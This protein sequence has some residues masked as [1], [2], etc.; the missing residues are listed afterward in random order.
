MTDENE[1]ET[2]EKQVTLMIDDTEIMTTSFDETVS[3]GVLQMSIGSAATNVADIQAYITQANGI[4][5][6]LNNGKMPIEYT[7]ESNEYVSVDMTKNI[8]I[9][10]AV[11]A[12]LVLVAC[13]VLV[14][15]FRAK[16]LK[17]SVTFIGMIAIFLL[18]IRYTNVYIAMESIVAFIVLIVVNTYFNWL[19]LKHYE[20]NSTLPSI[21][22][23]YK[24]SAKIT[25][26]CLIIAIV[27]C[28]I[29]WIPIASIGMILFWG[30]ISMVVT[31]FA[32]TLP[33]LNNKK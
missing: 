5:V 31:S 4:A 22:N 21:I 20:K 26:P 12:V 30:L 6:I 14:I 24:K 18:L 27:L 15:K 8:Q 13:L 32:I 10:V 7:I 33:I 1:T 19:V 11:L 25:I 23:A 29:N 16:G 2:K 3:N 28:F 17:V 9:G